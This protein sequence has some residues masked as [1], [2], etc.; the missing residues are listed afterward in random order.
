MTSQRPSTQSPAGT[1]D[2]LDAQGFLKDPQLWNRDLALGMAAELHLGELGE[3]HW[4]VIDRL[5]ADYLDS[6]QLPVQPTLCRELDLG[7]DCISALFGGPLEAWR[8]AGL[9][10]PGEEAR[11]YMDNQEPP[12]AGT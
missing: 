2:L 4:R 6:G 1:A 8:L 7:T 10:N 11:V 3:D 5:R 12:D 9:P